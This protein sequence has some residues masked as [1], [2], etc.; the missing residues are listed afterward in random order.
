MNKYATSNMIAIAQGEDHR[1]EATHREQEDRLVSRWN[2]QQTP[3]FPLPLGLVSPK[4]P[5]RQVSAGLKSPER[6]TEEMESTQDAPPMPL[7]CRLSATPKI[8][9]RKTSCGYALADS[10]LGSAQLDIE[11][12]IP[13]FSC[14]LKSASHPPMYPIRFHAAD[15]TQARQ[16]HSANRGVSLSP[17]RR[18]DTCQAA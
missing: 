11:A 8:P 10:M 17:T 2:S 3:A 4:Y 1:Q 6:L 5:K 15:T 9:M 14:P 7:P 16:K 12:N 13:S 18:V